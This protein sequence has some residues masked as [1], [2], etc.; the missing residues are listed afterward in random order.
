MTKIEELEAKRAKVLAERE[1]AETEQAE[2]D[3]EARFALEDEHGPVAEIK[4]RVFKAGQPTRAYV[5]M[6][7]SGEYR[8]FKDLV[9]KH[10]KQPKKVQDAADQLAR[11]TWVYPA[12]DEAKAAMLDAFPGLLTTI[13]NVAVAMANGKDADEGKD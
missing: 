7:E 8:R 2:R 11:A 3:L 5:R 9:Q 10:E 4:M 13:A 12:D 6:P 1:K